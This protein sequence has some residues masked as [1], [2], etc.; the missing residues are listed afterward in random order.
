D[1]PKPRPRVRSTDPSVHA[2]ACG[3][4]DGRPI[5]SSE[6]LRQAALRC[7]V[8]RRTD[9]STHAQG[10]RTLF[11]APPAFLAVALNPQCCE[12]ASPSREKS[13]LK[14][15]GGAAAASR[16]PPP[17]RRSA[18]NRPRRDRTACKECRVKAQFRRKTRQ[19]C[20]EPQ[21]FLGDRFFSRRRSLPR[22]EQK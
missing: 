17:E 6:L 3:A 15:P 8:R 18:G 11:R 7:A 1:S 19:V 14:W 16:K 22:E 9:C 12:G 20:C 2:Q 4:T 21:R 5:G 10:R 13:H